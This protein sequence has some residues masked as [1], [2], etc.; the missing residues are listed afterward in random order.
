MVVI[1]SG[2]QHQDGDTHPLNEVV[3]KRSIYQGAMYG[4]ARRIGG[5]STRWG[6]ALIPFGEADMDFADWPVSHVE[7]SRYL[8]EAE[9]LFGLPEGPYEDSALVTAIDSYT[10]AFQPRSAKWPKFARRNV[11]ALLDAELSASSGPEVWLD[12]T[13]TRFKFLSDGR[14]G[15]VHAAASNGRT[16]TVSAT[17]FVFA[18]G[19][20]ESTRLALLADR[21]A[22]NR[23]FAPD[24]VLGHYFHDHLS[25]HVA[26]IHPRSRK[27]L[28]RVVGFRFEGEGM[29]NLRF[30]P[31]PSP[32]IRSSLR[33]SFAHVAFSDRQGSGFDALRNCYRKLQQRRLPDAATILS[34]AKATPWLI[35]AAWWRFYEKRLLYPFDA[36]IQLHMVIEQVPV[37][38][39]R[40][41]LSDDRID[42]YGQ[43]LAVLDWDVTDA[44]QV[45]LSRTTSAFIDYWRRTTLSAI[46]TIHRRPE[47]EAAAQ[48]VSGG[49]I[50]HPGGS[51]RMGRS[52][53]DAVVDLDLTAFRVRNLSIAA[54]SVFPTGGGANPTML[55]VMFS[56][57]LAERLSRTLRGG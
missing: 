48:L 34:L 8:A 27:A 28:N 20:I 44:D 21:T 50:Y 39:N 29:R 25:A 1:E 54:T 10:P 51:T 13:A 9:A 45:N 55:L 33:P 53:T 41:L 14:L 57:R 12:A 3:H 18:A 22:D 11:A 6:G 40:I 56:L 38:E 31:D 46:G 52:P 5:T 42:R 47:T 19:A 2:T 15:P 23:I 35:N 7:I 17:E 36:D 24:H 4:R 37:M 26:D 16:I 43:P 49:G 32:E 30:E